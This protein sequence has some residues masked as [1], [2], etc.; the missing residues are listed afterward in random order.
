M[1]RCVQFKS[2][3]LKSTNIR[4]GDGLDSRAHNPNTWKLELARNVRYEFDAPSTIL[5]VFVEVK[6]NVQDASA[7]G[8]AKAALVAEIQCEIAVEYFFNVTGGP[9]G[10]ALA[11]FLAAFAQI[12][13]VFNAWPY[14]RETVQSL[15][16]RMGL[17]PLTLAVFRVPEVA[18]LNPTVGTKPAEAAKP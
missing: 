2:V 11:P 7:K 6:G 16:T 9:K 15:T 14:I 5:T 3:Y 8:K 4:R 17:P 18:A 13:G 12:N 10:D 1:A